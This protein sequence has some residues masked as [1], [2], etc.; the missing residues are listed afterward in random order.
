[1]CVIFRLTYFPGVTSESYK[2][3]CTLTDS[4]GH[5]TEQDYSAPP[6]GYWTGIFLVLHQ[7]ELNAEGA[8]QAGSGIPSIPDMAGLQIGALPAMPAMA[9]PEEGGF[10]V[11]DWEVTPGDALM[12]SKEWIKNDSAASITESGT[13]KLFHRPGE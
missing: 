10:V 6:S 12:A 13:L 8:A 5:V 3:H 2:I 7:E 1:M 9:M 4:D 11:T